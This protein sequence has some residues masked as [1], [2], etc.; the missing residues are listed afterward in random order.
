MTVLVDA[1]GRTYEI[2]MTEE[3][4]E[5][6]YR[7]METL[8]KYP[9]ANKVYR[10]IAMPLIDQALAKRKTPS[11]DAVAAEQEDDR[12]PFDGQLDEAEPTA[13]QSTDAAENSAGGSG[14]RGQES[15]S[16]VN[17]AEAD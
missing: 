6:A 8:S 1:S 2:E 12:D 3:E 14:Q 4:G 15:D 11:P 5:Q 13:G 10:Q 9:L 17:D 7:T 16:P